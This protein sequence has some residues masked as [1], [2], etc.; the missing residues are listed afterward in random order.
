MP[1]PPERPRRSGWG[2]E[3]LRNRG[4]TDDKVL[5]AMQRVPRARFLPPEERELADQDR[6]LPIGCQQTISQPYIVALMTQ[7]LELTGF[8]RVLEIGTGS[9]YQTAILAEL[10]EEVE[11]VERH[12]TLSLRARA[13]LDGL[14]YTNIHYHISDG[15]LGWPESAPFDRILVTAAAPALP[16][17]LFEQLAEAGRLVAPLGPEHDQHLYLIGK[18]QGQ[19]TCQ[20]LIPCRFVP[21]IG[22][23]G[24]TED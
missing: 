19:P 3:Q 14:G 20:A 1:D 11:T 17:S 12:P 2:I 5:E 15:T 24:W 18:R 13:L 23:E 7:E 4:I 22:E 16:P 8:E 6:A 10:A 9:G 21:L